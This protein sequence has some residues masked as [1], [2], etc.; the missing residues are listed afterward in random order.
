MRGEKLPTIRLLRPARFV[1]VLF[2]L[3]HMSQAEAQIQEMLVSVSTDRQNYRVGELVAFEVTKCNP[4]QSSITITHACPCCHDDFF[5]LDANGSQ[6]SDCNPFACIQIFVD[7]TWAPGQCRTE[8]KVWNQT[9]PGCYEGS[10]VPA[11]EYSVLHRWEFGSFLLE[12]ESEGFRTVN[13]AVI[14]TLSVFGSALMVLFF[15][16]VGLCALRWRLA[17]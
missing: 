10:A 8:S 11:G 4:T 1:V 3:V 5:I 16:L 2:C 9:T 6:V 17:V 13:V 12:T 7:V 15:M 14:P